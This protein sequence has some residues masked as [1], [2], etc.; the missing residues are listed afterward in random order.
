MHDSFLARNVSYWVWSIGPV[1]QYN[2]KQN[3]EDVTHSFR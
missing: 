2:V 3:D 1:F